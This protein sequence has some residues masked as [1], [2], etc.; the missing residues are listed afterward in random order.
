MV[1]GASPSITTAAANGPRPQSRGFSPPTGYIL[2]VLVSV[3]KSLKGA[4]LREFKESDR[5][6]AIVLI[7]I[8]G[9]LYHSSPEAQEAG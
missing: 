2:I 9:G 1:G 6:S 5:S 3:A 8:L 7:I 4:S